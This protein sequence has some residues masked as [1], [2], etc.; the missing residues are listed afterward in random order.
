MKQEIERKFLVATDAWRNGVTQATRLRQGYLCLDTART[1]RVRISGT[2]GWLT[3]KGPGA[4][5]SRAEYEYALPLSDATDLLDHLCLRPQIDKTRH[6]IPHGGLT[7]EVDVF[8]GDNEGLVMAEVELSAVDT[9]VDLPPWIGREVTGDHRYF[10][11][12]LAQHPFRTW[13]ED[14]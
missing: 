10:N 3:I 11:A 13:P 1:V 4:G 6:L 14:R 2:Q 5:P 7:F 12:Y 8:H 9:H